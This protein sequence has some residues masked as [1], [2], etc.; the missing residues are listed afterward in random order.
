MQ[1]DEIYRLV[2]YCKSELYN[3]FK[4]AYEKYKEKTLDLKHSWT[5]WSDFSIEHLEE[6]LQEEIQEYNNAKVIYLPYALQ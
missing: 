5:P 2:Q 3:I 4:V 6:R 1:N